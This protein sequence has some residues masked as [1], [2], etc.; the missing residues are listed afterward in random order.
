MSRKVGLGCVREPDDL[1]LIGPTETPGIFLASGHFRNGILLAQSLLRLW[2]IWSPQGAQHDVTAF[3][4]GALPRPKLRSSP[5]E[6]CSFPAQFVEKIDCGSTA[7]IHTT[8][9]QAGSSH[10][11]G[12]R[13]GR[14]REFKKLLFAERRSRRANIL[15]TLFT[16]IPFAF[17]VY[18]RSESK[19]TFSAR[20]GF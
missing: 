1:P 10:R 5:S 6:T 18:F 11:R 7:P 13:P 8:C 14:A 20:H 19:I 17:G 12:Q 3:S 15:F 2:P 9:S 4:P 16:C